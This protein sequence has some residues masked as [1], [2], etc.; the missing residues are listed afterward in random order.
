[1]N[2]KDER[3]LVGADL[4]IEK[5]FSNLFKLLKEEE[6][7]E[8]QDF[9]NEFLNKNPNEK[10][11]SGKSLFHLAL[12]EIHFNPSG[13]KLLSFGFKNGRPLPRYSLR[14]GNVVCL[15]GFQ[16][17]K[18]ENPIGTVYDKTKMK[19]TVAFSSKLPGWVGRSKTYQLSLSESVKTYE[20]M[21]QNLRKLKESKHTRLAH[22]R[23]ISLGL[24]EPK[25]GD[26][27]DWK[28]MKFFQKNLN[29]DQ[30]K[31]VCMALEVEDVLLLHG[32]PGTGKTS[33][34]VEIIKQAKMSEEMVL[35]SAPSN[36][37]CDHLVECLIDAEV[38]VTRLGHPARITEQIRKHTLDFKLT[39]HSY[40]KIIDEKEARLEQISR[41]TERRKERRVMSWTEKNE[42]R[43]EARELRFEIRKLRNEIFGQVWN[44]SDVVVTTHIGCGDHIIQTKSFKWVI[45]LLL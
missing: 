3:I 24:K 36:A 23:D 37:A 17:S 4:V 29:N 20:R 19:I 10:E 18:N 22:L 28:K 9:K 33:V 21:Y 40:G 42:T 6:A 12:S 35:V 45:A 8:R 7:R 26:P 5:H 15:S 44:A 38:P 14:S 25:I 43:D 31:A 41:Q 30:R 13:Q 2:K 1:M 16:T 11:K 39:E 27:I 32:P 34:L